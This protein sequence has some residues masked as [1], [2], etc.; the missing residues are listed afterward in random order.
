MRSAG[1]RPAGQPTGPLLLGALVRGE[2]RAARRLAEAHVRSTEAM[3]TEAILAH[4]EV[5]DAPIE[6]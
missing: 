3:V 1:A 5:E 2:G 6:A 4:K